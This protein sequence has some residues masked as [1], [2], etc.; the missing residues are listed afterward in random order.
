MCDMCDMCDMWVICENEV[1]VS[2]NIENISDRS[3]YMNGV[4]EYG[5][6]MDE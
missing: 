1:C 4:Y 3:V 2:E 5:G 6:Y